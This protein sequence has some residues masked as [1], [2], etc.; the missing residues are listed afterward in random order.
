VKKIAPVLIVLLTGFACLGSPATCAASA[1]T[2]AAA[3]SAPDAGSQEFVPVGQL[4]PG[5]QLP[6]SRLVIGA[7]SFVW[8]VLLSYLWS[9]R[10]R[11]TEVEREMGRLRSR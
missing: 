8:V 2:V 9:I 3:A 10:R 11:L 4:P 6:A 7:Y 1:D 5:E